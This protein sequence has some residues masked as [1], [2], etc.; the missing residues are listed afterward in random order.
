[1]F[2]A[3]FAI[4]VSLLFNEAD[5]DEFTLAAGVHTQEVGWAPGLA[6]G[7]DKWTSGKIKHPLDPVII[8]HHRR[9][10]RTFGLKV[11]ASRRWSC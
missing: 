11:L 4:Q 2:E 6:Q 5:V 9:K 1:M 3:V 8:P 10:A 7:G